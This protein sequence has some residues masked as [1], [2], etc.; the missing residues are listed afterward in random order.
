MDELWMV[1]NIFVIEEVLINMK[2][3]CRFMVGDLWIVVEFIGILGW[4][5]L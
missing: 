2:W 4:W 1:M 3:C 5:G